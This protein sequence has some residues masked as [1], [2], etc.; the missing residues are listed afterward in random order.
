MVGGVAVLGAR[1]P[2]DRHVDA[3]VLMA[4]GIL[5]VSTV[6]LTGPALR[7][8]APLGGQWRADG[9]TVQTDGA[10]V[11]PA[12]DALELSGRVA[13]RLRELHPAGADA[14]IGTIIA[15]GP[16]VEHVEQP[17][18]ELAGSARVLHPTTTSMLSA[19]VS[20]P[21]GN[22]PLTITNVRAFLTAL[23][24]DTKH[25]SDDALLAEGFAAAPSPPPEQHSTE[26]YLGTVECT[27]PTGPPPPRGATDVPIPPDARVPG[28]SPA[29]TGRGESH[30]APHTAR[31]V[32]P[33]QQEQQRTTDPNR[34][35]R[36]QQ[37]W[38]LAILLTLLGSLLT[39]GAITAMV[40]SGGS[41]E[42]PPSA[43][44]SGTPRPPTTQ[45]N[46]LAFTP[47][48]SS[49]TETCA[50]HAYGD[51]RVTLEEGECLRLHRASFTARVDG[52]SAATTVAVLSFP[53]RAAAEDFRDLA[54]QSGTGGIHDVATQRDQWP[55]PTPGF[56]GAA[57]VS[58]I[59]KATVHLVRTG[60]VDEPSRSDDPE[61]ERAAEAALQLP[62]PE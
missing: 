53:D 35:R 4:H 54:Q 23:A 10:A 45:V 40:R 37:R 8:D 7:L 44:G 14:R 19:T 39:A 18:T 49:A 36:A 30:P 56:S 61:L 6:T 3:V 27:V 60:W 47:Y 15:V 12:G 42:T 28:P 50:R 34:P 2:D 59:H 52:K 5:I 29:E 31:P 16:Y 46:G 1:S 51:L 17:A 48:A 43:D 13:E 22:D 20:M 38:L 21:R 57:Y 55:G 41:E 11:N 58:S 32:Q 26:R 62:L 25:P 24:P 9:W 33:A